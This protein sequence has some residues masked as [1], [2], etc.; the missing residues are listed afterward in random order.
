MNYQLKL[1]GNVVNVKNL[2]LSQIFTKVGKMAIG[3]IVFAASKFFGIPL[4]QVDIIHIL[5]Q[6]KSDL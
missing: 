4:K 6:I 1:Y 3:G 2:K 5:H